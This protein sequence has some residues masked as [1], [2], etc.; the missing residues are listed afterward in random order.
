MCREPSWHFHWDH[1][2]HLDWGGELVP[3]S[4]A[5]WAFLW[6]SQPLGLPAVLQG[7]LPTDLPGQARHSTLSPSGSFPR[8]RWLSYT[9]LVVL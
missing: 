2:T 5:W 8:P 4:W 3:V 7:Q 1:I 9:L 6:P